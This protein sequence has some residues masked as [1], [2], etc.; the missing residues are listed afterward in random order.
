MLIDINGW[1]WEAG[2]WKIFVVTDLLEE[3]SWEL[4]DFCRY[5]FVGSGKM[6]AGRFFLLII[7]SQ[8][9]PRYQLLTLSPK[10]QHSIHPNF[11]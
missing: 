4:E 10:A 5:R 1:K 8:T 7:S 3:G 2:S 9:T 11:F 6:E